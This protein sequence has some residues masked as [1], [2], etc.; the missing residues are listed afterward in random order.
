MIIISIGNEILFGKTINTNASFIADQ[1][2][3]IGIEVQKVVTIADN[4]DQ[5]FIFGN[6]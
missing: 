1:L 4:K 6:S 3:A 2:Y 5:I